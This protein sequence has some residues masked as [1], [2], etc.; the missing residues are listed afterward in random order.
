[1]SRS[2]DK[3]AGNYHGGYSNRADLSTPPRNA[4]QQEGYD[5][6]MG[7][8]RPTEFD[9][10]K[11]VHRSASATLGSRRRSDRYVVTQNRPGTATHAQLVREEFKG[12]TIKKIGGRFDKV[13]C[14]ESRL[15][16]SDLF[17][18][19]QASYDREG[20]ST[21][22]KKYRELSDNKRYQIDKMLEK[23]QGEENHPDAEWS[24]VHLETELDK[25]RYFDPKIASIFVVFWRHSRLDREGRNAPPAYETEGEFVTSSVHDVSRKSS[26]PDRGKERGVKVT[27]PKNRES[28][29]SA[30]GRERDMEVSGYGKQRAGVRNKERNTQMAQYLSVVDEGQ[31]LEKDSKQI[32]ID[33]SVEQ[34]AKLG[35]FLD[36]KPLR[37]RK[38]ASEYVESVPR[39]DKVSWPP[40]GKSQELR[41]Q[42][43]QRDGKLSTPSAGSPDQLHKRLADRENLFAREILGER[44]ARRMEDDLTNQ[45]QTQSGHRTQEKESDPDPE[46]T[47]SDWTEE[48]LEDGFTE[49]EIA[50]LL[51]QHKTQSPWILNPY[52]S[53]PVASFREH[54]HTHACPH[55]FSVDGWAIQKNQN[56]VLN[57]PSIDKDKIRS[58]V[59]Q[60]CGV[61]GIGPTQQRSGARGAWYSAVRFTEGHRKAEVSFAASDSDHFSRRFGPVLRI[62]KTLKRF[63]HAAGIMQQAG[64]CCDRF[65]VINY[66]KAGSVLTLVAVDLNLGKKLLKQVSTLV[67]EDDEQI[68][69]SNLRKA[70]KTAIAVLLAVDKQVTAP[71]DSEY[72]EFQALDL[73]CLAAQFLSIG[74]LFYRRAHVGPLRL[75]YLD[76]PQSEISLL[77]LGISTAGISAQLAELACLGPMVHGPVFV[78]SRF[79]KGS[80]ELSVGSGGRYHLNCRVEDLLDTFG[81]G[82]IIFRLKPAAQAVAVEV[83]G[84]MVFAS[85]GQSHQFHWSPLYEVDVAALPVFDVHQT[86]DIG[87]LVKVNSNCPIDGQQC[88]SNRQNRLEYLEVSRP[89][90]PLRQIQAGLQVGQYGVVPMNGVWE[91]IEGTHKKHSILARVC[92]DTSDRCQG[93][94][95]ILDELWGLKLSL[96]TGVACRVPLRQMVSELLETFATRNPY[97]VGTWQMLQGTHGVSRA[98]ARDQQGFGAW[99]TNLPPDMLRYFES[100]ATGILVALKDTGIDRQSKELVVAWPVKNRVSKGLRIPCTGRNSWMLLLAD[101]RDCATFAYA[102]PHCLVTDQ[103]SCG[104]GSRGPGRD[105]C[106]LGTAIVEV[107]RGL[108][109]SATRLDP[110]ASYY[111][112]KFDCILGATIT[113]STCTRLT[114]KRKK[115]PVEFW[116]RLQASDIGRRSFRLRERQTIDEDAEEVLA[117]PLD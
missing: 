12:F 26:L 62:I 112:E 96:C 103:R 113:R 79:D 115:M 10:G 82:K 106:T 107:E 86:M 89:Y 42:H 60:L 65:T 111:I 29:S 117:Y 59:D 98:L 27:H 57:R 11:D 48:L 17:E 35:P 114:I 85:S 37:H 71:D 38:P 105:I 15:S 63:L 21:A 50:E 108:T 45:G 92:Q 110:Q 67:E 19:A 49:A 81:P 18:K 116:L 58:S 56:V 80:H 47:D 33:D 3:D 20:R 104:V 28:E 93:L 101:S 25:V 51:H 78:F 2:K 66:Q 53:L 61:G 23:A 52:Y 94:F 41:V 72:F 75:H 91:K 31:R 13:D 54:F 1:M 97:P 83:G 39:L 74:L 102:M 6:S 64:I 84:G 73:C 8:V 34:P 9:T 40:D 87:L 36:I 46:P 95:E 68:F 24:L 22:V 43:G 44:G 77:G 76:T 5:V 32:E 100:L 4:Y 70:A 55:K 109:A 14:F 7:D 30:L 99:L 69:L 90:W 88:W 16:Q